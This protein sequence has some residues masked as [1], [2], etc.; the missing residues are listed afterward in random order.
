VK[1]FTHGS[2]FTGFG[3]FDRGFELAGFC[4]IWQI[5]IDDYRR[6][7][8]E[9][10]FPGTSQIPDI[11]ES[12]GLDVR[13]GR[14][15]DI[16]HKWHLRPVDVVTGGFPCQDISQAG[17]QLGIDVGER[18]GLWRELLRI[19][20]ELRPKYA[21]VENVSA[22]LDRDIGR[23]L[24]DLAEIG[25]DAEWDSLPAAA[26]G[27]PTIRDRVWILAYPRQEHGSD[28]RRNH[29]YGRCKNVLPERAWGEE[30]ERR[31][32]REL[33]ALVPGIHPRS[34]ADWWLRQ[35]VMARSVNGFPRG[36]VDAANGGFGDAVVPQIAEWIAHRIKAQLEK[37]SIGAIAE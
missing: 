3:G 33:V 5:E 20:C 13:K 17:E 35:S 25:Y 9:R 14:H 24:G 4:T 23:V 16:C 19:I 34:A 30:A 29:D 36:L 1:Q 6:R 27:A 37:E 28:A 22:L 7:V 8:L 10:H 21:V 12:C 2:C 18:S 11:T 32:D 15:E 26:F 31:D